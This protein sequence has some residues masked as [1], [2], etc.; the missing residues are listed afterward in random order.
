[1]RE[2]RAYRNAAYQSQ[3][4]GLTA[5]C[6]ART[7][8]IGIIT[9]NGGNNGSMKNLLQSFALGFCIFY[10]GAMFL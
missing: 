6:A 4:G 9:D 2:D 7:A 1:L 5:V 10:L 3:G 8:P